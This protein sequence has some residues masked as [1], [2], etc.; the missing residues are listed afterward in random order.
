VGFPAGAIAAAPEIC[1]LFQEARLLL[2]K[3]GLPH[4]RHAADTHAL[5]QVGLGERALE[6]GRLCCRA[7]SGSGCRW[8]ARP[9]MSRAC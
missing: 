9:S 4:T 2:W 6:I 3:R 7:V 1:I 5:D 8:R